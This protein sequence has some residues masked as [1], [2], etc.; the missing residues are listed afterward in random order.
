MKKWICLIAG[1]CLSLS[2]VWAET[3]EESARKI[4]LLNDVDVVVVG[5]TFGA[6]KSAIAAKESGASVFLVAPRPHLGEEVVTTRQLWGNPYAEGAGDPLVQSAFEM[7]PTTV[8][9]YTYDATPDPMHPDNNF[10]VLTD[11]KYTIS[12]QHSV[13]FNTDIVT[14]NVALVGSGSISRITLSTFLR[15]TDG[16]FATTS[17]SVST[18]LDDQEYTELPGSLNIEESPGEGGTDNIRTFFFTPNFY[19]TARFLKIRCSKAYSRQLL[20]ELV[21]GTQNAT[22]Q[23][24]RPLKV[25]KALDAALSA[26]EVPY[27]TG[28]YVTGTLTDKA[29]GIAGVVIANRNG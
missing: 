27:L 6:V 29:G 7:N 4:P 14:I 15:A 22:P 10:T 20:G 18:S 24:T 19:T 5:G 13:Q 12:S 25:E 16:G 1:L 28:S 11:G 23:Q 21:I 26:A 2:D 9:S 17:L 3:V 8:F